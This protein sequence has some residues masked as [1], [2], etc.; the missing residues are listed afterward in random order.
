MGV[1]PADRAGRKH[2]RRAENCRR[3]A[4][5]A[6]GGLFLVAILLGAPVEGGFWGLITVGGL[7]W[8]IGSRAGSSGWTCRWVVPRGQQLR[9]RSG[10]FNRD[11]MGIWL[12]M[13]GVASCGGCSSGWRVGWPGVVAC[14]GGRTRDRV[15]FGRP[16]AVSAE[17]QTFAREL[18]DVVSHAVGLIA[19]QSG[20][21][22]V[23][24]PAN[25][26]ATRESLRV[27]HETAGSAL[28]ELGRISPDLP[29]SD[30]TTK[31][32]HALVARI[33]A[34]GTAVE[35]H[36]DLDSGQALAPEVFRTVQEG[37]TNVVRHAPG[38][39][40]WV[41]ITAD[42]HETVVVVSD[43]GRMGT[44]RPPLVGTA[45]SGWPNG[46][47]LRVGC[48]RPVRG[49]RAGDSESRPSSRAGSGLAA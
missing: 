45:W 40:A 22:E 43:D 3:A 46:W 6:C 42:E 20:A 27:I 8:T 13:A 1:L 12:V 31:D 34:A 10:L 18:H 19:V 35:L 25:P 26:A 21:A 36:A 11:N 49:P 14:A 23:A 2:H 15:A 41:H 33:R 29:V 16:V 17:R 4:A 38:A 39:T 7:L 30:R 9:C 24:W 47:P 5:F 37:L 28:A 44:R 32:L 48:S